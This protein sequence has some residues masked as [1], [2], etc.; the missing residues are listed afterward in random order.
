MA[1]QA[2][3]KAALWMQNVDYPASWDRSLIDAF[4]ATEGVINGFAVT[5]NGGLGIAVSAGVAVVQGDEVA[6]QGKYLIDQDAVTTLTLASVGTTRTEYVWISI[7]DTAVAGGRA[8]NNVSIETSTTAPPAS[9]LLL[10]TLS[11]TAGTVTITAGMIADSRVYTSVVAPASVITSMIADSAVTTA[12]IADSAVTSAKIAD[13]TIATADIA[14]SAVTSA[15]IADGTIVTADIA[16]AAVTQAKLDATLSARMDAIDPADAI[17]AVAG[18]TAP[19]GWRL[20]DGGAVSRTTY[21]ATFARIGTTYGAGDGSTTFNVP[22]L[23]NRFI[24]GKGTATW[25]DT[26][27]ETGGNK[28]AVAVAHTHTISHTHG[29][30]ITA[31]TPAGGGTHAHIEGTE[32]GAGWLYSGAYNGVRF[33][34]FV[35]SSL[36]GARSTYGYAQPSTGTSGSGHNHTVT[37][38]GGVNSQTTTVSAGQTPTSTA[39]DTNLPPYRTLNYCIRL[40]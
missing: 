19:T 20:C 14:D 5:P 30:N 7:N 23:R 6:N 26:L 32:T 15:K 36:S 18:S 37:V 38:A 8:G 9:A 24:A 12:K 27:N 34:V 1:S 31:T 33:D 39:T 25:S 4:Y 35:G 16:D 21:A 2:L 28:D 29:H 3:T 17:I 13:G 10:A 40:R 11:L 22:D